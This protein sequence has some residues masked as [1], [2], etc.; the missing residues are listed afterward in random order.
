V[1]GFLILGAPRLTTLMIGD[2]L[3]FRL[4]QASQRT[5]TGIDSYMEPKRLYTAIHQLRAKTVAY[6]ESQSEALAAALEADLKT[7][8]EGLGTVASTPGNRLG[9][10]LKVLKVKVRAEFARATELGTSG[11]LEAGDLHMFDFR[12]HD[13]DAY[14]E[15]VRAELSRARGYR[16]V[17]S[18]RTTLDRLTYRPGSTPRQGCLEPVDLALDRLDPLLSPVAWSHARRTA[19]TAAQSLFGAP[20]PLAAAATGPAAE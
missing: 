11:L 9:A 17:Y 19:E 6:A 4:A 7:A 3:V 13:D 5:G 10:T 14:A 1:T 20:A 8:A 18:A 15:S 16:P 2:D 12:F